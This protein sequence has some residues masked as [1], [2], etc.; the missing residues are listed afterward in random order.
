MSNVTWGILFALGSFLTFFD[1]HCAPT[2]AR[3]PRRHPTAPPPTATPSHRSAAHRRRAHRRYPTAP[4]PSTSCPPPPRPCNAV[5]PCIRRCAPSAARCP[6][7]P[8]VCSRAAQFRTAAGGLG[9]RTIRTP[10][11][12][13]RAAVCPYGRSTCT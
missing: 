7:P 8:R 1:M 12:S 6:A 5:R 10:A 3:P 9:E 4:R 13:A 2:A 11:S